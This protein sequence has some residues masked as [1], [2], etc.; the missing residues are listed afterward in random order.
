MH[1]QCSLCTSVV[2]MVVPVSVKSE[3]Y[4]QHWHGP[5]DWLMHM[6]RAQV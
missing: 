2:R 4:P 6:Q 5:E 3:P 1:L